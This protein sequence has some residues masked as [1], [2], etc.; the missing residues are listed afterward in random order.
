M[1]TLLLSRFQGALLG[2]VIAASAVI[3]GEG[4]SNLPRPILS[5]WLESGCLDQADWREIY[6]KQRN[7]DEIN[8]II[9]NGQL[10]VLLLP[11]TLFFHE[12]PQRLEAQLRL[13]L[14]AWEM[15]QDSLPELLLWGQIISLILQ[16]KL[17]TP[18]HLITQL[19]T[20]PT[21]LKPRLEQLQDSLGQNLPLAQAIA[22]F[23]H[24]CPQFLAMAA[25][26]YCFVSTPDDFRLSIQRVAHLEKEAREAV[27]LT[28]ALAG[29]Y[30]SIS[31]IPAPWRLMAQKNPA[32]QEIPQ[33]AKTLLAL[34]SGNYCGLTGDASV[35]LAVAAAGTIQPR[36]SW[37]MI[38]Q[39]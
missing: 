11:L 37:Q 7:S 18:S 3:G 35:K 23:K 4:E 1:R 30:N 2:S 27:A 25:A 21:E 13:F 24:S 12:S 15:T 22:H 39:R 17:L 19:L 20:I 16:E 26:L 29:A 38:S 33:Q 6:Q 8:D 28:G 34:W 10:A 31:G 14:N 5:H 9:S 36:R 32:L